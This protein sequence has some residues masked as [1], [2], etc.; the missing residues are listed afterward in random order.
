MSRRRK[1]NAIWQHRYKRGEL[2][3]QKPGKVTRAPD[4]AIARLRRLLGA[5]KIRTFRGLGYC[6]DFEGW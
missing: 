1:R 3:V 6:Y 4:M 2:A 5:D